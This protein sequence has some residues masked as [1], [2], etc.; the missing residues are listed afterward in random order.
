MS[1]HV[2]KALKPKI[3]KALTSAA[4]NIIRNCFPTLL[5]EAKAIPDRHD[6]LMEQYLS[7]SHQF[8]SSNSL[9]DNAISVLEDRI[10]VFMAFSRRE[11]VSCRLGLSC[12]S[13]PWKAT[14]CDAFGGLVLA[15]V[16]SASREGIHHELNML[17]NT[18]NSIPGDLAHTAAEHHCLTTPNVWNTSQL[19]P[20]C[21]CSVS[22]PECCSPVNLS[23]LSRIF[24]LFLSVLFLCCL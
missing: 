12:T 3:S 9:D 23:R 11:V 15:W 19:F 22:P 16:S 8:N 21:T 20:S 13:W 5:H 18:F 17:L 6:T 7:W 24:L 4:V 14:L 10:A 2:H 1:N